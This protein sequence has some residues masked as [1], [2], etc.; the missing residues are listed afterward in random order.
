MNIIWKPVSN[1]TKGRDGYKPLGVCF[2]IGDGSQSG[3]FG[4]ANAPYENFGTFLH[5]EKSSHYNIGPEG[6]WQHVKE[7]DTAWTQ[8]KVVK[9]T[10]KLVLERFGINPNKFLLS[11]ENEGFG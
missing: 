4:K 11:V 6:I 7:E 3:I 10:L 1:F 2:H 9:P 5:E 8:G